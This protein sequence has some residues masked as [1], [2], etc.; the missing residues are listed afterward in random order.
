MKQLYNFMEAIAFS[1]YVLA[2]GAL[3]GCVCGSQG[4]KY[5]PM[6]NQLS[7]LKPTNPQ[8]L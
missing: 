7:F 4:P 3:L 2:P 8:M 6:V 5:Q 1:K